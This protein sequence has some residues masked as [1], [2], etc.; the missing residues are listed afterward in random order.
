MGP[1]TCFEGEIRQVLNNLVGNAID[2][3]PTS[4]KLFIRS[5]ESTNWKTG[6][7][8]I[9]LTVADTGSGMSDTV[10]KRIFDPFF[11]T[12]GIGG[13]GLGSWVSKEIVDRH[14]GRLNVRSLQRPE[15]SG[16]VFRLFLPFDAVSRT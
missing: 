11:T 12:K 13:T 7:P 5:H 6:A 16:S 8:G 1:I 2:A 14:H 10:L 15:G 3:M 9:T 4:G